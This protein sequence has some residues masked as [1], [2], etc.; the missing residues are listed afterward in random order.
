MPLP[1]AASFIWACLLTA[2]LLPALAIGQEPSTAPAQTLQDSE[3]ED[4]VISTAK[5]IQGLSLWDRNSKLLGEVNDVILDRE[6]SQLR[7]IVISLGGFLGI[8]SK[9][10]AIDWTEIDYDPR[11]RLLRTRKLTAEDLENQAPFDPDS[12]GV[13]I[14]N[15]P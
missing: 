13:S 3:K 11:A 1:N 4:S 7:M 14:R 5:A 6:A 9:D 2:L 8:G 15:W 10:I 12:Q